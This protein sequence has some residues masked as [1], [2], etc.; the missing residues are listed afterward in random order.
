MKSLQKQAL[1]WIAQDKEA[2]VSFLSKLVQC[3]TPSDPGDTR[4]AMALIQDFMEKA[5]LS[6]EI[7]Q[8]NAYMPNLLSAI[9]MKTA[10]RHLMFNGHLDVM[11]AGKEPGW[12]D[13]P[14]SGKIKDGRVWG[15]GTSDMKAGVTAMLF[16]Y[17]YL[18]RL[19]E[20]LSGKVSL[21]L[22]SD[23]ETGYERG[24]GYLFAQAESKMLADCVL[25]GEPSGTDAISFASKGYLQFTVNIQTRGAIA[26]YSCES[27]SAIS[28]AAAVIADLKALEAIEVVLPDAISTLRSDPEKRSQYEA[29][30]GKAEGELLSK[31]TADITTIQGGGLL[32][33]IAPDCSFTVAVVMP[34]GT[35]SHR[36]VSSI[37]K[38]L[39]RYPEATWELEG[40]SEGDISDPNHEMVGI[41]QDT[42]IELGWKK[43]IPV[44]DIALS[45]CRHWRYRGIPAFW[46][47][48]DGSLCSAA[49]ESVEIEEVLHL[50]RTYTL[51]AIQYLQAAPE[52][53]EVRQ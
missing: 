39:S 16:A 13:D 8:A 4:S 42:V 17:T 30:R 52:R 6:Y 12:T 36:I 25:T 37:Q 5:G 45:D 34:I 10:G 44:A 3:K 48:P 24:T 32:S 31:V 41:L 22:V 35:E 9:E 29:V 20:Q 11:P 1:D 14:W 7:R 50:V 43:P 49:N 27:K 19:Q 33:V 18:S 38:I 15:R 26:G 53:T 21:S 23:E 28:I 51:A 2:I 40:I 47:G 46:Y